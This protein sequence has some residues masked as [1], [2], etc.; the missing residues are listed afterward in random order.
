MKNEL[1]EKKRIVTESGGL[2][3]L[4]YNLISIDILDENFQI[5]TAYGVEIEK[6]DHS[7]VK[8]KDYIYAISN[9]KNEVVSILQRLS[10]GNVTPMSLTTVVDEMIA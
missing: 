8:E 5:T 1:I 4:S 6:C 7:M 10:R 9:D 3:F 2:F